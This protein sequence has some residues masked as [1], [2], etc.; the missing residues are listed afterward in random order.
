[1]I[2]WHDHD[3]ENANFIKAHNI[4][5]VVLQRSALIMRRSAGTGRARFAALSRHSLYHYLSIL[6]T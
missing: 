5:V 1:M 3:T 6:T 2:A 4:H